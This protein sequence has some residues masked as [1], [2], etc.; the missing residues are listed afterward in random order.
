[1]IFLLIACTLAW[2]FGLHIW[3]KLE[4]DSKGQPM[5]LPTTIKMENCLDFR[6]FLVTVLITLG[7]LSL[8]PNI[9]HQKCAKLCAMIPFYAFVSL[10][11]LKEISCN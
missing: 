1:M 5:F 7:A 6:C 11:N 4:S 2:F 3:T 8:Q 10:R 9:L